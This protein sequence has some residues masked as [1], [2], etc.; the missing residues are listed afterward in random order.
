MPQ[1]VLP[2]NKMCGSVYAAV[3]C[4]IELCNHLYNVDGFIIHM[5]GLLCNDKISTS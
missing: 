5:L 3:L 2:R 1:V 4:L